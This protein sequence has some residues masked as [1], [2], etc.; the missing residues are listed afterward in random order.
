MRRF[1]DLFTPWRRARPGAIHLLPAVGSPQLGN[2]RDL[3]VYT[4]GSYERGSTRYPVIYMQDGQ[5]LFDPATSFAGDWGLKGAL[6]RASRRG[7]ETI[8]VA[9]PNMGPAR[10]DEY[11]PFADPRAGGGNGDQYLRFLIDTVKPLVDERFRTLPDRAHTGIAGSSLGGLISLYAFFDQPDVFGFTAA[12]SPALWFAHA[13]IVH[14][15]ERVPRIGGRIYFDVGLQEGG[16]HVALARRLRDT[17][18][19]KGYDA[20]RDLRFVEDR[21]GKHHESAWGRRFRKALPFLLKNGRP[22]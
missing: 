2:Q 3:L 4:P 16:A 20:G 14:L 13:A 22:A 7:I 5:N 21:Y 10:I 8:V 15:A 12:F 9:I 6:A 18:L 17:L 1:F 19:A 11:S